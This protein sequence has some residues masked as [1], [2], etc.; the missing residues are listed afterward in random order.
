M[1]GLKLV[2]N[3]VKKDRRSDEVYPGGGGEKDAPRLAP[4]SCLAAE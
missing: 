4:A 2:V 3:L 1:E